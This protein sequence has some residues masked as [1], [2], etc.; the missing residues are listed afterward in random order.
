MGRRGQ[1]E[2]EEMR[3][4]PQTEGTFCIKALRKKVELVVQ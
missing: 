2:R 3:K 4:E 1:R